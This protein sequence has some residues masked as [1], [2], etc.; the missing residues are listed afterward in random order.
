MRCQ[1]LLIVEIYDSVHTINL[2]KENAKE[3]RQIF[4]HIWRTPN[5]CGIIKMSKKYGRMS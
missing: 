5:I 4:D 2:T 3:N 1:K